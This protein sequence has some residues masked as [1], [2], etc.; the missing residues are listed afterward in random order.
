MATD[1]SAVTAEQLA[2]RHDAEEL[3]DGIRARLRE[4]RERRLAFYDWLDEDR[5]AEFIDGEVVVHSPVVKSHA[6]ASKLLTLLLNVHAIKG[7]LGWV[8]TEKILVQ[9][10]RDDF[11]PDVVFWRSEVAADFKAD[12]LFFPPP[13]FVAEV[14]SPSTAGYDREQ[15][16]ASYA[17]NG[18]PE[19][20]I[21]DAKARVVEC[22]ELGERGAYR[23]RER[24]NADG[25]LTSTAVRGFSVPALAIYDERVNLEVVTSIVSAT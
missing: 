11:E 25:T 20:W 2:R 21:V 9:L 8:G 22:Y 15:K 3:V 23:L 10:K 7:G 13:H 24:V 18:V 1:V 16:Y 19:Y 6:D 5:K 17:A 4:E 12:Q 14:L